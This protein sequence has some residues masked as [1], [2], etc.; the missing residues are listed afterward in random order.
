[1]QQIERASVFLDEVSSRP[2]T[3]QPRQ[4]LVIECGELRRILAQMLD[5][6]SAVCI[7][8]PA[9]ASEQ[10]RMLGELLA[11]VPASCRNPG[12]PEDDEAAGMAAALATRG[13]HEAAIVAGWLRAA[14]RDA[15]P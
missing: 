15:Q 2:V 14:R 10:E 9:P 12:N 6:L 5:I 8:Q 4:A 13:G 11:E 3:S 1:M 7:A